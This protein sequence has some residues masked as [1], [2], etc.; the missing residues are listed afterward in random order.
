MCA[1]SGAKGLLKSEG[2]RILVVLRSGSRSTIGEN[3]PEINFIQIPND[4]HTL[5]LTTTT[6]LADSVENIRQR[7]IRTRSESKGR[8]TEKETN[9]QCKSNYNFLTFLLIFIGFFF[10]FF[11]FDCL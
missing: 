5:R 9:A 7:N 1:C 3:C 11:L 8:M 2:H 4:H 10:S 6:F